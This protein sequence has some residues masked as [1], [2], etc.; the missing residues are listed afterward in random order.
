MKVSLNTIKQYI[1]IDLGVDE[2]VE[3]INQQLGQ[4]EE[5]IDLGAK[6]KD[7]VIVN[8]VKCDKHPNADKLSVCM[9]DD[10]G[11][12]ADVPRDEQGLVQVVCGAPNARA[13]I[14]AAWLPPRSTVPATFS[15]TEPFV[16]DAREL[17]GVVSQG[18][19]AAPDELAIGTGHDGIIEITEY[20]IPKSKIQHLKSG[21]KFA[22]LFDLDDTI[23]DIENKMFTHRPDCFGQLGVAREI[24]AILKGLPKDANDVD[25]R[26]VNP[27]WYWQ[28]PVFASGEGLPLTVFNDSPEKAPRFMAV[29]MK[30]V[31]IKPS[32]LWLQ[33][34]L[35][36]MGS[37]AINNIVDITNYMMLL[38]AQPSHAYD[39]DKLR[40]A[41]L[42]A[43]M[44]QKG[45]MTTLLN[46]KS[47]ELAEDDVV[48]ADGEGVIG[49]AGIMGGGN[50]EVSSETKNIV[51]EVA[52][53]D[54]YALRKSS[55]RHGIFT[56][57]L[58]RFSKGQSYL[59]NDRVLA[60]VM[61]LINEYAGSSQASNVFDEPDMSGELDEVS[62][63]GEIAV[64]V[65]FINARLGSTLESWQIG[66]LLRRA[67]FASYPAEND[68][69]TLLITAPFWRTDIQDPEDIVEE[70]GRLYGFDKIPRI[71]PKRSIKPA[72]KNTAFEL[73]SLIRNSLSRAGANEVLSYSFVHENTLKK[74]EQD[75]AKAFRISNALSPD[76]QYYRLSVLPSLL[77]K[78]HPNIKSGHDEF[79]LFEIG[80][81]HQKGDSD[82]EG[83]PRE[84]GMVDLVYASKKPKSGAAYYRVQRLVTRLALDLGF[85]LKFA[86][87]ENDTGQQITASFNL[88]RSS[89]IKAYVDNKEVGV[90]GM[91]G[92][93]KASVVKAFKLP[94]YAAA[95]SLDLSG[96][97]IA[98]YN[99]SNN[100]RPLSRF[101]KITQDISLKV[102]DDVSYRDVFEDAWNTVSENHPGECDAKLSP[103]SIY[104]SD[105]DKNHKTIT[106]RLEI[107]SYERTLT[108]KDVNHLMDLV[109]DSAEQKTGAN[110]I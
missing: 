85:T 43:R 3:R 11:V 93:L 101:P 89:L 32:P 54:M 12:V 1:D 105:D 27:D 57:A 59:Q 19:L 29:A 6:Y 44:A 102:G 71:L 13:G 37:K 52:N 63:H 96:L 51:I 88:E 110:R 16:L 79:A 74:S 70:V 76:L 25:T 38:T 62:I 81:G 46:G 53:F 108:D 72:P 41:T 103:L 106:L 35:V 84:S 42:G 66:G 61:G 82:D 31:E 104:Q 100:Y 80:K 21:E 22:E 48:I 50:S 67:N 45:E 77:D 68:E 20:D 87:V 28:K 23:I 7:V 14:F 15:D 34:E 65:G 17:R 99:V 56:D 95:F 9:V 33:I 60:R 83:L 30:D 8:V 86:P 18:M 90:L 94:Q 97:H 26:F 64:S 40:G 49:L 47:Y 73:K 75:Y 109:A 4:V 39:Y 69:H 55:M 58:T 91:V 98:H 92:E 10:G 107:A 2:L 24:S 78:V 36:R 5:V